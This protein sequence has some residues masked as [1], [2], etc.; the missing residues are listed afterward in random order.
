MED[1]LFSGMSDCQ[2]KKCYFLQNASCWLSIQSNPCRTATLK[3]TRVVVL[4]RL[5]CNF[6]Y[7]MQFFSE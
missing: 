6:V 2:M 3:K 1:K 7:Q 5:Y 4:H